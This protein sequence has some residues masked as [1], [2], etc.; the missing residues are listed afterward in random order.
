MS[1][2]SVIKTLMGA[3]ES[4]SMVALS[5]GNF[6]TGK[7]FFSNYTDNNFNSIFKLIKMILTRTSKKHFICH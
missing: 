3:R 1:T 5:D 2:G 7:F 4:L 6:V